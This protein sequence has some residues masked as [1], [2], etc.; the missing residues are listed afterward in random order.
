MATLPT[1][2]TLLEPELN[3]EASTERQEALHAI[4]VARRYARARDFEGA[5]AWALIALAGILSSN[6]ADTE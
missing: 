2:S 5:T 1:P 4:S 3:I 6:D